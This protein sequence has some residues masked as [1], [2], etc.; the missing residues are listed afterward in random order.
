MEIVV[1]TQTGCT[2]SRQ[3][4]E[5][6]KADKRQYTEKLLNDN[7]EV[8]LKEKIEAELKVFGEPFLG[9]PTTVVTW[10]E[11][12][13]VIKGSDYLLKNLKEIDEAEAKIAVMETEYKTERDKRQQEIERLKAKIK[14]L[15]DNGMTQQL[16]T[17][18]YFTT[19]NWQDPNISTFVSRIDVLCGILCNYTK[20]L[21]LEKAMNEARGTVN[22]ITLK[23]LTGALGAFGSGLYRGHTQSPPPSYNCEI[24]VRKDAAELKVTVEQIRN[25]FAGL[26]DP[27]IDIVE[28][29]LRQERCT[30]HIYL[31]C[32]GL[33]SLVN[34]CQHSY[35][36]TLEE[37]R[38]IG[39]EAYHKEYKE[40]EGCSYDYRT[41]QAQNASH[42][43]IGHVNTDFER[44]Y[45]RVLSMFGVT[46]SIRKEIQKA[47]TPLI[48]SVKAFQA[49]AIKTITTY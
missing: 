16:V 27:Q 4:I 8:Y 7:P 30:E 20:A 42:R 5:Q 35:F 22:E 43:A 17:T 39:Q 2:H 15:E 14:H 26:G 11:K 23:A 1:Y 28:A 25:G 48:S 38:V 32:S 46:P 21:Q 45:L 33:I 41:S 13:L 36:F 37:A 49:H 9:T 10:R 47:A 44:G 40:N 31:L 34:L 29:V 12:T 24:R 18:N 3:L 6:L 19:T